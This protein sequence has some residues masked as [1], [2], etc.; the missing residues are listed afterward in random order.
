MKTFKVIKDFSSVEKGDIFTEVE[1]LGFFECV[2]EEENDNTYISS[3]ITFDKS[4][5][6]MLIEKEYLIEVDNS[7][8]KLN[9]VLE[10]I[11]TLVDTYTK[12]YDDMMSDFNDGKVQPCVKVEAETVYHNILKVLNSIKD[13][14]NE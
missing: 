14:I 5:I 9:E 8:D 13:K 7:T 12:D 3:S 11:N 6:N 1:G 4:T 2:K 10:Y